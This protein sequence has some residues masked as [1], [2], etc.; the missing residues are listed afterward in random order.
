MIELDH[1]VY[2]SKQSPDVHVQQHEGTAIGGKHKNWGTMNALTYTKNSYIEYLTVEH[3]EVAQKANHPLITLLL[4][5]LECGEGWGTICF[6]VD[7]IHELNVRLRRDG[8]ETSGVLDAER[9]TSSGFVRKWKMLFLEQDVSNQLPYP[10][11]IEWQETFEE[12]MQSLREDGTLQEV[13]ERLQIEQCV[14]TVNNPAY[15]VKEWARI[16]EVN[17]VEHTIELPNTRI[18]FRYNDG[19]KERLSEVEML[20]DE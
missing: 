12:R 18:V 11:F 13:N 8:W 7:N 9:E 17:F 5:D 16:L 14:I 1:V 15:R 19:S 10:F 20:K 4:N 6:R 2:F 3:L